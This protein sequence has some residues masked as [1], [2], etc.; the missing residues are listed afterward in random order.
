MPEDKRGRSCYQLTKCHAGAVRFLVY[1]AGAIGGVVGARLFQAGYDVTLVA[2]GAHLDAIRQKGLRLESPD[3][4]ETLPIPVIDNGSLGEAVA[5][6]VVLLAVKSQDTASAVRGLAGT[7]LAEAVVC[8]Q[9]GVD[10]ERSAL[11]S[12]DDVYGACVMCP[13]AHLEP[14]IVTAHASPV[15]GILDL[16]RYP[17]GRDE[18]AAEIADVL[19]SATFM[20]QPRVDIMR[21]KYRK[22]VMNLGNAVQ[23]LCGHE[24]DVILELIT[25]EALSCFEAAGIDVVTVEEDRERRADHIQRLPVPGRPR[26]GGSSYQSLERRQGSIETDY[27][28]G[29]ICLLGRMY[30]VPTPANAAVQRL[31]NH[32]AAEH[33]EPGRM[34]APELLGAIAQD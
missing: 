31:A 13:A 22:L 29:E 1:G 32:A 27:L 8:L 14:G 26:S 2:R 9:N 34:T 17:A 28:N 3:G 4:V 20:S 24:G 23:A 7:G 5:P 6:A 16:G 12:F 25:Q 19:T 30:G 18:R 10:N 33:W 11:R 15:T 21:W